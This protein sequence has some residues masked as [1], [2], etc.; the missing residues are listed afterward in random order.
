[1]SFHLPPARFPALPMC[2]Q[3]G[4]PVERLDEVPDALCERVWFIAHCHGQ[5]ERVAIDREMLLAMGAE[6][7]VQF[8][9]AFA[10]GPALPPGE[11]A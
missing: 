8:V 10:D 6:P 9:T 3:C 4:H 1:M 5:S 7:S 11:T 2:G